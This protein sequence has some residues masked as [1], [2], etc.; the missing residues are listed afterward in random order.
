MSNIISILMEF[1]YLIYNENINIYKKITIIFH[2]GKIFLNID[3][4]QIDK[5][6]LNGKK[7][8]K[9]LNH[10]DDNTKFLPNSRF[11][12]ISKDLKKYLKIK[13]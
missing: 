8:T 1:K 7:L 10:R 11:K 12:K 9:F 5:K 6:W 2:I 13:K 3:I 4:T